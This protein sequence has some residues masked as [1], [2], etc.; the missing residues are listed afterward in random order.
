MQPIATGYRIDSCNISVCLKLAVAILNYT[1]TVM[2]VMLSWH[3]A[4]YAFCI[5]TT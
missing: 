1:K 5:E 4:I 2:C 3:R